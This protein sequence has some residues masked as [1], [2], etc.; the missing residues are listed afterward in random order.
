MQMRSEA[1]KKQQEQREN[2]RVGEALRLLVNQIAPANKGIWRFP[3]RSSSCMFLQRLSIFINL[4]R[5]LSSSI[6]D[7]HA[8]PASIIGEHLNGY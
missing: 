5:R 7:N 8:A 4:Y 6:D 3:R 1:A 2:E